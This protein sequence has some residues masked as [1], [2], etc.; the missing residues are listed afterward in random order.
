M[1]RRGGGRSR[2][3]LGGRTD[4]DPRRAPT[5]PSF[6]AAGAPA[7]RRV[8]ISQDSPA[9]PVLGLLA[10]TLGTACV[11]AVRRAQ[12]AVRPAGV[13]AAATRPLVGRG[14]PALLLR[15]RYL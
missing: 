11:G 1:G 2:E 6:A 4:A 3:R 10:L 9:P 15:R 8:T 13:A 14:C 5:D 7:G 12:L